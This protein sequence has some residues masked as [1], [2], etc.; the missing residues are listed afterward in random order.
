MAGSAGQLWGTLA[1]KKKNVGRETRK[2]GTGAERT[3]TVAT[4]LDDLHIR[5][6]RAER[7][8]SPSRENLLAKVFIRGMDQK[9]N[10]CPR[11]Y[12]ADM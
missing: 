11:L 6:E 10:F 12:D 9:K 5:E 3:A 1:G 7:A 2:T 8:R 4:E